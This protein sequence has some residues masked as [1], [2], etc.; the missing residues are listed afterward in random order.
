VAERVSCLVDINTQSLQVCAGEFN[1]GDNLLVSFGD[2]VEG[3]D[4]VAELS[5]KVCAKGDED[6]EGKLFRD[7][8]VS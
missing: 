8:G 6:P 2:V 5:K 4:I 7:R 1:L 3:H